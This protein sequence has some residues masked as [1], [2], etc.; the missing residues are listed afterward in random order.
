MKQQYN[1]I[2]GVNGAESLTPNYGHRL[3]VRAEIC[4]IYA[5]QLCRKQHCLAM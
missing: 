5:V 2:N 4:M 1:N 3:R